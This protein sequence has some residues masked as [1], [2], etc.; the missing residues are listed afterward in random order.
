MDEDDES[1][2]AGGYGSSLSLD[3]SNDRYGRDDGERKP[4]LT[5]GSSRASFGANNRHPQ[6]GVRISNRGVTK[7]GGG[8]RGGNSSNEIRPVFRGSNDGSRTVKNGAAG[9][10]EAGDQVIIA[11]GLTV[12]GRRTVGGGGGGGSNSRVQL[13]ATMGVDNK[14]ESAGTKW[15]RGGSWR[16]VLLVPRVNWLFVF[17]L[18]SFMPFSKPLIFACSLLGI[19]PLAERLGF[20]TEQLAE[21]SSDTIGGLLNA[22]FGNATEMIISIFALKKGLPRVVQLSLLGSILSNMMLV[23]GCAF[24][25]GGVKKQGPLPFVRSN[26][27]LGA[28]MMLMAMTSISVTTVLHYTATERRG[29]HSTLDLSRACSLVMLLTYFAY[30]T[31]LLRNELPKMT[32]ERDCGGSAGEEKEGKEEGKEGKEENEEKEENEK[33]TPRPLLEVL[34]KKK[35]KIRKK[36]RRGSIGSIKEARVVCSALD[37]AKEQEMVPFVGAGTGSLDSE[38]EEM[39]MGRCA[40]SSRDGEASV[41]SSPDGPLL[42]IV[43]SLL[44]MTVI[45]V[46]IA[47][48][49]ERL[50]DAI[51]GT[52]R[53]WQVP[54][55]F[56]SVIILPIVGN[57]AEHASAVMFALNEKLDLSISVALGSSVQIAIFVIPFCVVVG[58][59]MGVPMDLNFQLFE[60]STLVLCVLMVSYILQE[61]KA[62]WLRGLVLL[63]CYAIAGASFYQHNELAPKQEMSLKGTGTSGGAV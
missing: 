33:Y 1:G 27:R 49:S 3:I 47:L 55:A 57:A 48:L 10:Q 32:E 45:T 37:R 4:L 53:A 61:G 62:D 28:S 19:A 56:I 13:A 34:R 6:Q 42:G 15:W 25:F 21:H 24:F 36:G 52:S 50:V 35:K 11:P 12:G 2:S 51:E 7:P 5:D 8:G 44:W 20:V 58:W 23:L 59:I 39:G 16:D 31:F 41:T 40:P 43:D 22:T 9:K 17:I 26:A 46:L 30:I 18:V 14:V 38:D 29:S 54:I 63:M 60:T